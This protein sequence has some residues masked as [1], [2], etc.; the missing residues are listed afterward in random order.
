MADMERKKNLEYSRLE[1]ISLG[2]GLGGKV[3]LIPTPGYH[4]T[5]VS[6]DRPVNQMYG[7]QTMFPCTLD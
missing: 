6:E 7:L 3:V 1:L 2:F 5:G 4:A